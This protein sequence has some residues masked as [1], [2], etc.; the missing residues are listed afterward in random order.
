MN[1]KERMLTIEYR[2]G[3]WPT[4]NL[5]SSISRG[6]SPLMCRKSIIFREWTW[7]PKSSFLTWRCG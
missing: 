6:I 5:Q 1:G 2:I 3:N 7:I 4:T